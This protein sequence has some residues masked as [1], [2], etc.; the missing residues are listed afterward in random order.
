M[1]SRVVSCGKSKK[2]FLVG[3]LP[4]TKSA[5]GG[6]GVGVVWVWVSVLILLFFLIPFGRVDYYSYLCTVLKYAA[7]IHIISETTKLLHNK[8]H[9][10]CKKV[11][12]KMKSDETH[13]YL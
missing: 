8:I 9:N 13:K 4:K 5:E 7:K 1:R 10:K 6:G 11:H 12:N 3:S 2:N